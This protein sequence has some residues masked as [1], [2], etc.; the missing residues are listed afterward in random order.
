MFNKA[1]LILSSSS[2]V[3]VTITNTC[4]QGGAIVFDK[5]SDSVA[6]GETK[7]VTLPVGVTITAS[8]RDPVLSGE[9]FMLSY[10]D[11]IYSDTTRIFKV[12][13]PA[14]GSYIEFG[15]LY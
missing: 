8:Y 6:E 7:S 14:A 1:F 2:V 11:N 9:L 5:V 4:S 15:D 3:K 13:R 12:L 10:S